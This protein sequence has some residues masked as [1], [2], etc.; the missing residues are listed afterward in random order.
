M[1]KKSLPRVHA[2]FAEARCLRCHDAHGTELDGTLKAAVPALCEECHATEGKALAAKHGGMG[3]E[4]ANCTSCHAP[5][6]SS[7]AALGHDVV[8]GPYA[9]GDCAACH[10]GSRPST[11]RTEKELCLGCH[12]DVEEIVRGGSMHAPLAGDK[13]CTACHAPH[14]APEKGLLLAKE[15]NL[16]ARCH[17]D[18]VERSRTAKHT[19]PVVGPSACL[20]CHDAHQGIGKG[21]RDEVCGSCHRF[22]EH[23]MH[24]IGKDVEL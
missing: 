20:A 3:V 15:E 6:A 13:P 19:H 22:A 4:Q 17:R 10:E 7:G 1:A 11:I 8:H 18:L 16:C 14:A 12:T 9:S 24:P 2:P 23:T 5:H 21:G